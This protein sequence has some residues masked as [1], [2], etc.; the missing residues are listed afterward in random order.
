MDVIV[1]GRKSSGGTEEFWMEM[2][3]AVGEKE[4]EKEEEEEE[5]RRRRRG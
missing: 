1:T 4:E 3:G 5:E 2:A